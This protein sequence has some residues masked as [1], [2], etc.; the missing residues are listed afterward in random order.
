MRD[1]RDSPASWITLVPYES[2]TSVRPVD[3]NVPRK[4]KSRTI[5]L[6]R[7]NGETREIS[8]RFRR[9]RRARYVLKVHPCPPRAIPIAIRATGNHVGF[10][11]RE[12]FAR[13]WNNERES[14]Y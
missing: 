1:A 7:E 11:S 2:S 5:N 14:S 4:N 6:A 12:T 10:Q 8:E 3:V 9:V 13:R